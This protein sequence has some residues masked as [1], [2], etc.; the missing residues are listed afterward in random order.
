MSQNLTRGKMDMLFPAAYAME[1][2]AIASS[3]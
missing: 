1:M 3:A 2:S